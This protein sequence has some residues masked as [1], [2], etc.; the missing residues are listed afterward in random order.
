MSFEL[1]PATAEDA[2]D[3]ADIFVLAMHKDAYWTNI[4]GKAAKSDET[5]YVLESMRA[6]FSNQNAICRK[7]VDL[8]TGKTVALGMLLTPLELPTFD[9]REF[10]VR[11]DKS[12]IVRPGPGWNNEADE[13][14]R[15]NLDTLAVRHGYDAEKHFM[16]YKTH[17]LPSYQRK[18]LGTLITEHF[19]SIADEAGRPTYARTRPK[20]TALFQKLGYRVVEAVPVD[21]PEYSERGDG[22]TD[23]F[24]MKREPGAPNLPE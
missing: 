14:R 21:V 4:I 1:Q 18:G 6:D 11:I 23:V 7:V 16:R 13:A 3:L 2:A 24:L 17:V 10:G 15:K 8:E 20:S 22:T 9:K 12:T 5:A 19:N